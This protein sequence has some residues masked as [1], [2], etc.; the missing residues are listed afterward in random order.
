MKKTL[1]LLALFLALGSAVIA[2]SVYSTTGGEWIFSWANV[3][4]DDGG[5]SLEGNDVLRWSPVINIYNYW[6]YDVNENVG[7][8]LGIG[9]HNIG[10]ITDVPQSIVDGSNLNYTGQVRKKFR[11][12]T[13]G[14][15]VGIKVGIMK[16]VYLYGGYE[17]EFPYA[18]KE[19]TIVDGDKQH[20]YTKWFANQS[21]TLYNSFFIGVQMRGGTSLKF[22]Y[23]IDD[24]FDQDYVQNFTPTDG[25][26][27]YP[28]KANMMYIS[29]S[30][31]ILKGVKLAKPSAPTIENGRAAMRI[32]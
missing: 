21:P 17:I 15:P 20:K 11:N 3:E 31:T 16:E 22:H 19:K 29:I 13:L 32:R 23:Y 10:F 5:T 12:Y 9:T 4:Y 28:S 27:F 30:Q 7:F 1:L 25:R 26:N 2:Q 24:F 14:I 6:H 18:Y 8:M